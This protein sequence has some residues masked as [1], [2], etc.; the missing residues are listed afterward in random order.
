M[1][2]IPFEVKF[3]TERS[4]QTI[5][6]FNFVNISVHNNLDL[7]FIQEVDWMPCVDQ[8]R[9]TL[10]TS[11]HERY[12]TTYAIIDGSEIFLETPSDLHM[13]SSTWSSYKHV[14]RAIGRMK[15][16][17][18]LKGVLPLSLSWVSNQIV[19]ICA[20]IQH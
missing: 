3:T 16:F 14:E 1:T 18:I 2:L 19:C 15:T 11:F 12:H 20:F 10:P 4:C 6:H 9:G 13:Q 17:S 5:W 7:L 8:L